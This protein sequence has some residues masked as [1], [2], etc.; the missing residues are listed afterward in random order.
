MGYNQQ[1]RRPNLY[2][3]GYESIRVYNRTLRQDIEDLR[4]KLGE[5]RDRSCDHGR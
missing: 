1:P 3:I 5:V 4:R 2:E